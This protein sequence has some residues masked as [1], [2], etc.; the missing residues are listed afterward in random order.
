[1]SDHDAT[2]PSPFSDFDR[3]PAPS[4]APNHAVH[5]GS[6]LGPGL[7]ERFDAYGNRA[8]V[9]RLQSG[10]MNEPPKEESLG[11]VVFFDCQVGSRLTSHAGVVH[12][13]VISLLFDEACGWGYEGAIGEKIPAVTGNLVVD[14]RQP[15]RA[16]E[17]F[18]IRVYHTRT[19]GRKVA[20]RASLES[21]SGGVVYA[22]ATCLY[23]MLRSRL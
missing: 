18:R 23:I 11:E 3:L 17:R 19:E 5:G 20:L 9:R 4:D 16:G 12:G 22:D 8:L 7:I 13:G 15:L 14:F 1:M 10:Q 21:V 6:L 2:G